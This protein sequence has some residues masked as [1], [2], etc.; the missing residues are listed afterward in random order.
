MDLEL[1]DSNVSHG[2][3][4]AAQLRR[5]VAFP[6]PD[7]RPVEPEEEEGTDLSDLMS[8]LGSNRTTIV[9][10]ALVGLAAGLV[11]EASRRPT[12]RAETSLEFQTATEGPLSSGQK[13]GEGAS[14]ALPTQVA[15]LQSR[16]VRR[17]VLAKLNQRQNNTVH[18]QTSHVGRV[19]RQ[20][21]LPS[22]LPE[23]KVSWPEAVSATDKSLKVKIP[24]GT[25]MLV[26]SAE[27]P[28]PEVAVSYLNELA[29]AFVKQNIEAHWDAA[30]RTSE[31]LN[32][33]VEAVKRKLSQSEQRLQSYAQTS[34]LIVTAERDTVSEDSLKN[35]QAELAKATADRVIKQLRFETATS[36]DGAYVPDFINDPSLKS[37]QEQLTALKRQLADVETTLT[38]AHYKVQ[39]LQ[40]Q[41]VEVQAAE[42]RERKAVLSRIKTEYE[43]AV[44]HESILTDSYNRQIGRVSEQSQ[45][46]IQYAMLKR[47]LDADRQ[48]YGILLQKSKEFDINSAMSVSSV[49]VVDAADSAS[50]SD[51]GAPL[52]TSA[53]G[54]IF[55]ALLGAGFAI[56]REK[57]F[58]RMRRPGHAEM[59]LRTPE[60][61]VIPTAKNLTS[62]VPQRRIGRMMSLLDSSADSGSRFGVLCDDQRAS[63]LGESF[64][65]TVLSIIST[66]QQNRQRSTML[67]F[68]SPNPS[69]GKSTCV[70]NI[71]VALADASRKVLLIDADLRNPMVASLFRVQNSWGLTDLLREN[72]DIDS[73]PIESL[74]RPVKGHS[75]LFLLTSGPAIA[76]PPQLLFSERLAKLLDRVRQSFDY[77]L[78]DTPPLLHFSDTRSIARY[79]D[80][81]VL[82][83]R[84][85]QTL[86]E[87]AQAAVSR[88]RSDGTVVLGTILNDWDPKSGAAGYYPQYSKYYQ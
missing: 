25:S 36:A 18:V 11:F 20:M 78:V 27:S 54:T 69:E 40:A 84:S 60:L 61:G 81:A 56:I 6:A 44:R 83:I 41:V 87:D 75:N 45:K 4:T 63:V 48:L 65:S 2:H 8:V 82:V 49:R 17:N 64:R 13:A 16:L 74:S 86:R 39:R 68:T 42:Q 35:A 29:N 37:Y 10:L 67:V 22:S 30:R 19:L 53:A 34:G 62:A 5:R 76:D 46:G 72:S 73:L 66:S 15:I 51:N 43:E 85:S 57:R 58:Q 1:R 50:V 28:D 24:D 23:Q 88:L 38:P 21:H 33:Q 9:C 3:V 47:E 70:S 14:S 7:A 26:L 80:G 12:Y 32:E 52:R 31:W 55:G 59:F 77:V 79:S 71:A